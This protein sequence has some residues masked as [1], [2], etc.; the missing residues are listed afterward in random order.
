MASYLKLFR[1]L[2]FICTLA[3]TSVQAQEQT[4]SIILSVSP[5]VVRWAEVYKS[6]GSGEDP[7]FHA[8]V[9][10]KE[11]GT[12]PWV[13]KQLALHLVV[14]P[15]AVEASRIK[16]RARVYAYKDVEFRS[17]YRQWLV[18]PAARAKTPICKTDILR[19]LK[20]IGSGA[21]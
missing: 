4:E 14:T 2:T 20:Q 6:I 5:R 21:P 8:R 11:K 9:F 3:C 18:D 15:Q 1:C 12:K 13:F 7:Y 19:C 17:A 16:Q 10:E